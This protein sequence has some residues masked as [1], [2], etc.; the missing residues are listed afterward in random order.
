[1]EEVIRRKNVNLFQIFAS[2]DKDKSGKMNFKEWK[3]M[4]TRLSKDFSD[5]ELRSVFDLID[6]DSSNTIE[7]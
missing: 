3:Y 2:F 5:E 7:F 6:E 1:M 4:I